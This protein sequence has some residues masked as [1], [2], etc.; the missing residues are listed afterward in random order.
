M[1][2]KALA[3]TLLALPVS[4]L[5]VFSALLLPAFATY[6]LTGVLRGLLGYRAS[7]SGLRAYGW[8]WWRLQRLLWRRSRPLALRQGATVGF[9]T[10]SATVVSAAVGITAFMIAVVPYAVARAVT[11]RPLRGL[12]IVVFLG[13]FLGVAS[14][15]RAVRYTL[16]FDQPQQRLPLPRL[17]LPATQVSSRQRVDVARDVYLYRQLQ[18]AVNGG[19]ALGLLLFLAGATA[20]VSDVRATDDSPGQDPMPLSVN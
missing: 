6:E 15:I 14:L 8:R 4:E 19:A 12:P 1:D 20:P 9:G 13:A 7:A 16:R 18:F 2:G 5:V 11:D 10:A 3:W 17:S